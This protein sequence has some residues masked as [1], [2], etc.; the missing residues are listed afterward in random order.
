MEF[1]TK[2]KTD[3]EQKNNKPLDKCMVVE[4]TQIFFPKAIVI[5]HYIM[6]INGILFCIA[7]ALI[8]QNE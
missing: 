5:S 4:N 8:K 6:N 2:I 3:K 1:I 7:L